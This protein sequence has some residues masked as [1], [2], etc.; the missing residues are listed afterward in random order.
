MTKVKHNKMQLK[1]IEQY[2]GP[3]FDTGRGRLRKNE[4]FDCKD[5]KYH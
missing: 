5:S 3:T 1:A 2:R 4:H